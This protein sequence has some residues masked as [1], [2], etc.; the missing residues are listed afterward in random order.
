MDDTIRRGIIAGLLGSIGDEIIHIPAYFLLGTTTTAHYISQLIFP[1]QDVNLIRFMFGFVTHFFAGA[2]IGVAFAI[3]MKKFGDD[4][5]YYKGIGVA[6]TLWIVHVV[7]IPNIVFP[8]PFL[9]RNEVETI[10]DLI[11]HLLYGIFAT[12]Y[13]VRRSV[14]IKS[15][16]NIR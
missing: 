8:R 6:I 1:F 11:G 10:V 2:L 7:V 5:A 13:L 3:I 12:T 9:H 16:I 14:K 4:Y 15:L